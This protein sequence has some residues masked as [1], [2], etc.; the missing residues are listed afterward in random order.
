[1]AALD[2][3]GTA[4]ITGGTFINVGAVS[5]LPSSS[6]V[7]YIKF[8]SSSSGMGGFGQQSSS[9]YSF[10][11]GTWQVLDSSSNVII[12]FE[13]SQTYSNL[14]I[15]SEQILTSSSYKL[16]NGSSTYSWTQSSSQQTY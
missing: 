16:T 6:S 8:G 11:S 5:A 1:M 3:D 9:S 15:A 12:E 13:L 4:T 2:I 14:W 10:T 7:N